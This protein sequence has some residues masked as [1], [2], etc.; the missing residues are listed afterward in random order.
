[1]K[2]VFLSM[3]LAGAMCAQA[4]VAY[5][6]VGAD[7]KN[8]L[9]TEQSEVNYG[10]DEQPDIRFENQDP[11]INFANWFDENYVFEE[12]GEFIT[13][14]DIASRASEFDLLIINCD[15]VGLDR[16]AFRAYFDA[17]TID[18]LKTYVA[19]GGNLYLSKQATDLLYKMGRIG[20]EPSYNCSG[21]HKGGDTWSINPQLALWPYCG[22]KQDNREHPIFA[23]ITLNESI[24][25]VLE[26]VP[27][28]EG[29]EVGSVPYGVIELVGA[30]A[31][32]D[33][34]CFWIDYFRKDPTTGGILNAENTQGIECH[35]QND[36]GLRLTDFEQDWN[37]KPLAAWGQVVDCCA[38]GIVEWYGETEKAG[39][40]LT[41]GFAAYQWG[42]TNSFLGNVKQLTANI[43]DYL[44][45]NEVAEGI[46]NAEVKIRATK[47]VVDGQVVIR[48][49]GINYT[50]LGTQLNK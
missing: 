48:K 32:T 20:Y 33:N 1:M 8:A 50:I 40:I 27:A 9:P 34:N 49:N 45:G 35:Y 41:N 18:A 46:E 22:E 16:D 21:Y 17:A 6:L 43:I 15:R 13:V 31:R 14:S 11:E 47:T 29:E 4:N 5:V 28:F 44:G 24:F 10:T 2:K 19:N 39:T 23:G 36:N 38:G 12:K 26:R 37:C 42:T 25:T 30:D 7:T 3:L